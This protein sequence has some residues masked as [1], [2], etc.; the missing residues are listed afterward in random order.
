[1]NVST[2]PLATERSHVVADWIA[3]VIESA[4]PKTQ[5][6]IEQVQSRGL[7]PR[8]TT[9][10]LV[11]MQHLEAWLPDVQHHRTGGEDG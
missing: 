5:R 6:R 9:D 7:S 11:A 8:R 4:S 10:L 1:M 2:A 3:A